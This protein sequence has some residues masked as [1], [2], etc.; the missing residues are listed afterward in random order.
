MP[1][2][3]ADRLGRRVATGLVGEDHGAG[4]VGRGTALEPAD[5]LPHHRRV[6]HHLEVD[7]G[8]LEVGVGVL[9]RV[10]AVLH[11]H[12]PA[13]V[14]GRLGALDVGADVGGEVPAGA[15]ATAATAAA[16]A[17]VVSPSDCFSNA[18]VSTRSRTPDSHEVGGDDGGGAADAAGGVDAH[19]RLA[20]PRPSAS[21][22]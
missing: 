5:G 9:Q 8:Q 17:Q 22:R 13:D 11:R 15:D 4:A 12:H 14:L 6:A 2:T 19:D 20:R 18:T 7:V 3:H 10:L 21:A 1:W 16:G